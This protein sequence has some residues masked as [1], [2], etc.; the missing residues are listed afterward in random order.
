MGAVSVMGWG[1]Q[2]MPD[3]PEILPFELARGSADAD[4]LPQKAG[5]CAGL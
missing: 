1:W 4:G 5:H 3:L 2:G